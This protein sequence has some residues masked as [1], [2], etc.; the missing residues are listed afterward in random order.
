M[1]I[2]LETIVDNLKLF[3]FLFITYLFLEYMERITSDKLNMTLR[4]AE[5]AGPLIGALTGS[6]PQCGISAAASNFYAAR[7][8]S[9]GT[10]LA[11]FLATSDEML[12]IFISKAVSPA[13]IV[14]I[15]GYKAVCGIIFGYII[16]FF[17]NRYHQYDGINI[18]QLCENENCRCEEGI[19]R[20]ALYHS[21]KITAFIFIITLV[22]NLS[23]EFIDIG[24]LTSYFNIP[25]LGEL[26]S[27]IIG[28]IPNCSSSVVLTQ[29]YLE[30]YINIGTLMSGSL[31]GCGV[32]L[33]VLL[34]VNRH[35]KENFT[36]IAILC[37]CALLGGLAA[38]IIFSA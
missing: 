29:L 37:L 9:L 27:I 13:L 26:L 3:P 28:L 5:K 34:R 18:E 11:A 1:D 2:L 17:Y 20:P 7:V 31:A 22:L 4:K 24:V 15:M 38:N 8:I 12:P 36:I 35:W 23:L 30:N 19:I 25:V 21:L 16:N 6:I 10:L 14:C 33:L 32:G